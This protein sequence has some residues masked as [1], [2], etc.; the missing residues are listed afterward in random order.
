MV[1]ALNYIT[2]MAGGNKCLKRVGF[3][4]PHLL[5]RESEGWFRCG[6]EG[7]RRWISKEDRELGKASKA[8]LPTAR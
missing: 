4:V 1:E 8:G 6:S 5:I 3:S 7:Q 2:W